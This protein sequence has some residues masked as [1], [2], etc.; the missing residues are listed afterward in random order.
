MR[1]GKVVLSEAWPGVSSKRTG[2]PTASTTAWILVLNHENGQWRDPRPLFS[3]AGVLMRADDRGV[4][5]MQRIRR[6]LGQSL[7]NTQPHAG[8]GPAI[9]AVV[10]R[11]IGA[12]ALRQIAPWR[13]RSQRPEDPVQHPAIVLAR[14]AARFVRQQRRDHRPFLIAQIEPCHHQAP[15]VWKLESQMPAKR[16]PLCEYRT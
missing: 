10:D 3:A 2:R 12:V 14:H 7:E 11:R 13:P 4:D 8:L 1:L 9:V 6:T 15:I 5:Q 16:N